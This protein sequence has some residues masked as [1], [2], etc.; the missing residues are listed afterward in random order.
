MKR[1]FGLAALS[2]ALACGTAHAQVTVKIGVLTDMSSLYSDIGGPRSVAAP[3]NAVAD[4]TA[5]PQENQNQLLN[6]D[7]PNK[8]HISPDNTGP[9]VGGDHDRLDNRN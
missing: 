9:W 5:P 8:P 4:F 1:L 3:K 2:A 6:G 7:H